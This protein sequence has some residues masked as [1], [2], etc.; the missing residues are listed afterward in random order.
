MLVEYVPEA[1]HMQKKI[2]SGKIFNFTNFCAWKKRAKFTLAITP[3]YTVALLI[4][5]QH[6][7]LYKHCTFSLDQKI[8]VL[9][10]HVQF[11]LSGPS[12]KIYH[13]MWKNMNVFST[14]HIYSTFTHFCIHPSWKTSCCC[15][16][17]IKVSILADYG[18]KRWKVLLVVPPDLLLQL[19]EKA[20]RKK[21][22]PSDLAILLSKRYCNRAKHSKEESIEPSIIYAMF[23][24]SIT[25]HC[26]T[27]SVLIF[28]TDSNHK[29]I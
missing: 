14:I 25:V 12:K 4:R 18:L 5:R 16:H 17:A 29:R 26:K 3:R 2:L 13:R 23:S 21:A 9:K 20:A 7:F 1:M 8:W 19:P 24:V 6:W 11:S 22:N 10:I 28:I 27:F 15:N